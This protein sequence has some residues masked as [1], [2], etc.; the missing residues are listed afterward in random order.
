MNYLIEIK[1]VEA[2][3]THVKRVLCCNLKESGIHRRNEAV[4]RA[5]DAVDAIYPQRL[6]REWNMAIPTSQKPSE[7]EPGEKIVPVAGLNEVYFIELQQSDPVAIS[8]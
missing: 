7:S 3:A 8:A 6:Y 4:C 5:L 1:V 2:A